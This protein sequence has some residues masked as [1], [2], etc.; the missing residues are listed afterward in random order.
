MAVNNRKN[1]FIVRV[2]KEFC[3]HAESDQTDGLDLNLAG[4]D[5]LERAILFATLNDDA[6]TLEDILK[7]GQESQ[8]LDNINLC[9][10]EGVGKHS[11]ILYACLKDY[12]KCIN[13]L[14]RYGYRV[15]LPEEE[16]TIIQEVLRTNNAVEND[17]H[18]YMK[19]WAGDRHVDQVYYLLKKKKKL[20]SKKD[21][22]ERLLSIKAFANPH[23]IATEFMENC[24]HKNVTEKEFCLY[25]PVRKSLALARYTKFLSRFYV[26][27]SQEYLEISKV[28]L[29]SLKN[30]KS[31]NELFIF[32][33]EM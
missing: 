10:E 19:L 30:R 21:P 28:G 20:G 2:L 13:V 25:D 8:F 18:F 27:Y 23:Y 3:F 6:E 9:E 15:N 17:Y 14:Y 29:L 16:E 7:W 33:S 1:D 12:V 26:Q 4:R 22:V 31:N 5:M 32:P 24:E 11:P